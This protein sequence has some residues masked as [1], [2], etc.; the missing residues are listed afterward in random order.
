M[1]APFFVVCRELSVKGG[2]W[3]YVDK[4]PHGM[5]LGAIHFGSEQKDERTPEDKT[6]SDLTWE[7]QDL[8][9][10]RCKISP[11]ILAEGVHNGE[12]CHFAPGEFDF[13]WL[14]PGEYRNGEPFLSRYN[15]RIKNLG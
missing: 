3:A 7:W 8:G 4:C 1:S 6:W 12:N 5:D 13:M 2:H 15:E 9:N 14:E 10:G 11:S